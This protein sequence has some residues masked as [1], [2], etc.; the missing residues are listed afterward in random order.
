MFTKN[1]FTYII[2]L[3]N[4][5]ERFEYMIKILYENLSK[6][7]IDMTK[8]ELNEKIFNNDLKPFAYAENGKYFLIVPNLILGVSEI[9]ED[10]NDEKQ[11]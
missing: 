4:K 11:R 6:H 8:A 2:Y 3:T 10:V 5:I 9:K 1:I 7:V